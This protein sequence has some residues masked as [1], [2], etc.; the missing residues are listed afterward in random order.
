MDRCDVPVRLREN[1]TPFGRAFRSAAVV[2]ALLAG[3]LAFVTATVAHADYKLG[4]QDKL[5][6]KVFEWRASRG[7]VFEWEALNDE[8]TVGASGTVSLPLVGDLTAAGVTA[9]E[10]ARTIA[11]RLQVKV[12]LVTRPD[13]SVEVITF[14]PFYIVGSVERPGEYAFRPGLTVLQAVGISGGLPRITDL[15]LMRIER[16][17]MTARGDLRLLGVEANNLRARMAR[18]QAELTDADKID[19]AGYMVAG[20]ETQ[21]TAAIMSQE[22]SIFDTRREALRNQ[23]QSLTQLKQFLEKEVESLKAQVET[24]ERQLSLVRRELQSVGSLVDKGL[25]IAP[26]QLSLER[27]VAQIEGDRLRVATTLLRARQDISRTELLVL[28]MR[29]K[30]RNE[31][32]TDIRLTQGRLDELAQKANTLENLAYEAEVIFPD[33]LAQRTRDEKVLPIYS[34][35]R[36]IGGRAIETA[37]SETAAVEPGD[38]IKVEIPRAD[39]LPGVAASAPRP[40]REIGPATASRDATGGVAGNLQN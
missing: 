7:E 24:E 33:Y 16:E 2:L 10:L 15:G 36:R 29:N 4:A 14:R 18:L 11:E 40:R 21:M 19:F 37:V 23:V 34:V 8:F 20:A 27:T 22:Q 38:T 17:A 32:V 30:Q 6:I 26:R 5:R 35:V 25:A 28:E 1:R 39:R 12:G 3:S 9:E 31:V 13:A